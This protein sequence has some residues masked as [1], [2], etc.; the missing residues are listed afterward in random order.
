MLCKKLCFPGCRAH[1][2]NVGEFLELSEEN[3]GTI[4]NEKIVFHTFK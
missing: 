3:V 2:Q 4:I 1:T